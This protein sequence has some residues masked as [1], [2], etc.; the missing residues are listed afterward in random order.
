MKKLRENETMFNNDIDLIIQN[1]KNKLND[2][3]LKK[4]KNKRKC[5]RLRDK[6]AKHEDTL[7]KQHQEYLDLKNERQRFAAE[8]KFELEK[9]TSEN[10]QLCEEIELLRK[11]KESVKYRCNRKVSIESCIIKIIVYF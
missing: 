8:Q 7:V 2:T 3:K 11:N 1:F 5:G 10:K 9:L 6:L 4:D